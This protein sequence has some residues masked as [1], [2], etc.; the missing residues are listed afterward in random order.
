MSLIVL[1]S[2]KGAPGVSTLAATMAYQWPQP[3]RMVLVEADA[4]GGV[5]AARFGLHPETPSLVSFAAGARHG[6]GPK[7][8]WESCQQ[9]PGGPLAMVVPSNGQSVKHS[10]AQV[11]FGEVDD[12]LEGTD[13]IIDAG[14]LRLE[15]TTQRLCNR[16]CLV[17]V[18]VR[19][20]FENLAT[21]LHRVSLLERCSQLGVVIVGDGPYPPEEIEE[22]LSRCSECRSMVLGT[23]AWDSRG[24]EAMTGDSSRSKALRRSQIS[25]TTRPITAMVLRLMPPH[26]SAS[27]GTSSLPA[28]FLPGGDAALP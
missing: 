4:D 28:A 2:L 10:L 25:R 19:P 27:V 26:A 23:V 18:V 16:A 24:A 21:L 22:A 14:R 8:F 6:V 5:L 11:D 9:L 20:D 12:C 13:L 3:R 7:L 1:G 15:E 17:I